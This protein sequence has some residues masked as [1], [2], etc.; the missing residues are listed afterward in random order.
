MLWT[1]K[2][3]TAVAYLSTALVETVDNPITYHNSSVMGIRVFPSAFL[4][5]AWR[6]GCPGV[7]VKRVGFV[8]NSPTFDW[9]IFKRYI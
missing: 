9:V 2:L 4:C 6:N 5:V 7:P 8:A 1:T 3:S